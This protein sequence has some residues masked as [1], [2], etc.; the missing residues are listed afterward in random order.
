MRLGREAWIFGL[1][2]LLFVAASAYLSQQGFEREQR[3]QPTTYSSGEGGTKALYELYQKVGLRAERYERPYTELP[4]NGGLLVMVE[5]WPRNVQTGEQDALL[6][7]IKGGGALLLVISEKGLGQGLALEGVEP[8]IKTDQPADLAPEPVESPFL[9]GVRTLHVGGRMRLIN[10][11]PKT[12]TTLVADGQGAYAVSW[13]LGR[14]AIVMTTDGLG[15][16]NA[17]IG[18]ADNG[19]F[20]VN[21]AETQT[22]SARPA[23][24]FDEYHQGFGVE[25]GTDKSVWEV[26]G[27]PL[28]W[29]A[30]YL[31]ALFLVLLYSANRR[32]GAAIRLPA[33]THR[34]STEYLASMAGFFR[35][36]R[37]G[38]IALESIYRRFTRELAAKVEAPPDAPPARLAEL[39]ARRFGWDAAPLRDL[40]ARCEQTLAEVA[41][42]ST[43][44]AAPGANGRGQR[45][46]ERDLVRLAQQI[47]DYRRKAELVRLAH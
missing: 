23:V 32:F 20:Y 29:T 24:L 11:A 30:L 1:L 26:I 22:S 45:L 39:S 37:A 43:T 36:A 38:D 12:R 21:V 40:L 17:S 41:E 34:A 42:L 13:K 5:P 2:L 31:A 33:P 7:W 8:A 4:A 14:G 28:R 25:E 15:A 27:A 9:R 10:N 19:V 18:K 6:K 46:T 44:A 16:G 35:R 47:Q 3:Y